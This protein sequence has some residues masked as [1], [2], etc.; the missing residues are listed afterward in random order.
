M[1]LLRKIL[2]LMLL[3][4]AVGCSRSAEGT[5]SGQLVYPSPPGGPARGGPP[6]GPAP[7]GPPAVGRARRPSDPDAFGG[8]GGGEG[9]SQYLSCFLPFPRGRGGGKK[10][11]R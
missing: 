6:R 9:G 4:A 8:G 7:H 5:L 1:G 2:P 10:S 3:A 11:P